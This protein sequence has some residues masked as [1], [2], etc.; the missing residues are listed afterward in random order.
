MKKLWT[1]AVGAA[2]LLCAPFS[3]AGAAPVKIRIGWIVPVANLAP[4]LFAEPGVARHLGTSYTVEPVHFQGTPDMITALAVGD[5]DIG[6]LGFSSLNLAVQN[7]GMTDLRIVS[8][9][10]EDGV[11][12]YATN[13]FRVAKDSPIK[14]VKDLKGKVLAINSTG[15]AVDIALRAMLHRAGLENRR[16]YTE[17]EAPFGAMKAMLAQNKVALISAVPPFSEDPELDRNS[18]V[19]FTERDAMEGASELGFWVAKSEFVD[20]NRAALRDFLEDSIRSVRWY[21]DPKNHDAAVAI[22]SKFAKAP[23]SLFQPWIFTK[24]DYYR[25]PDLLPNLKELQANI[26]LQRD[27]GFFSDRIDVSKYTDLTLVKQA[28]ASLGP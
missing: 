15:S 14:S 18:R 28:A 7:A 20:Q 3:T 13:E 8:D 10:F 16:D 19:L 17:V 12:D 24:K 21:L 23:S 9:E 4:I 1:L 26:D 2:A 27:M 25:N 11:D 6:V 5:L 22:A